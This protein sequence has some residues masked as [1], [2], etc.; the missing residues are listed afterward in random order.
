MS[1]MRFSTMFSEGKRVAT[2]PMRTVLRRTAASS[3]QDS[4]TWRSGVTSMPRF[5]ALR[6]MNSS[7]FSG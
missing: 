1:S 5:C 7:A 3:T 2:S 6:V 4:M